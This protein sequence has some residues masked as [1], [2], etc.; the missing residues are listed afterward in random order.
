LRPSFQLPDC[1]CPP[2]RSVSDAAGLAHLRVDSSMRGGLFLVRNS[3]VVPRCVG[4]GHQAIHSGN[5]GAE[6]MSETKPTAALV[7]AAKC[8]LERIKFAIDRFP[9]KP[10]LT[11][12]IIE[13][14]YRETNL[15]QLEADSKKLREPATCNA[16]HKSNL[17]L[18]LWDCPVCTEL[19]RDKLKGLDELVGMILHSGWRFTDHGA[20][21][22]IPGN[23]FK[24]LIAQASKIEAI[25]RGEQKPDLEAHE[26]DLEGR[27]GCG[28]P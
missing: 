20:V 13:I 10:I 5:A 22:H 19:L 17:P 27:S 11:S 6:T 7:G 3:A 28:T 25:L 4:R 15:A 8:I 2:Q 23:Q 16:G 24:F 1:P 18:A 12:E 14:V 26:R 21:I 9:S